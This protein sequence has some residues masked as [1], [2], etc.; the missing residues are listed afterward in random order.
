MGST[1]PT[2]IQHTQLGCSVSPG[3]EGKE[4]GFRKGVG[5]GVYTR[6]HLLKLKKVIII[7]SDFRTL[8]LLTVGKYLS[9][10]WGGRSRMESAEGGKKGDQEGAGVPDLPGHLM[11]GEGRREVMNLPW[12]RGY[13][14][15]QGKEAGMCP[16]GPGG[17]GTQAPCPD[18]GFAA[19][20]LQRALSPTPRGT[21]LGLCLIHR[22]SHSRSWH[23]WAPR[24]RR[25]HLGVP[26]PRPGTQVCGSFS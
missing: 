9:H 15:R 26:A 23:R 14:Q 11:G 17:V 4:L 8:E 13:R 7:Q 2:L 20:E 3:R 21:D 1:S 19:S 12:E 6:S 25:Q 16:R 10:R 24:R 18:A 5:W 22:L